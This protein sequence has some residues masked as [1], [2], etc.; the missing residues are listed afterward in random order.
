MLAIY[1]L[2]LSFLLSLSQAES[3]LGVYI[4]ARH[5]DRT[6][7]KTPPTN[8][9]GLGYQE[10]F[11]A[12]GYFRDRYVN[13]SAPAKISGLNSDIV[14]Q[15]QIVASAPVDTVLMNSAEGFL[16]ALYPPAAQSNPKLAT[17]TLRNGTIVTIP[18]NNF[19]LIPLQ[20]VGAGAGAED[21][22]WLQS[23]SG[24][25]NSIISSNNYF[26]SPQYKTILNSTADFYKSLTPLINDT[27]VDADISF[28]NA[29]SSSSPFHPPDWDSLLMYLV[30]DLINVASIHNASFDPGKTL[31]DEKFFQLRQLAD[32]HEWNLAYNSSDTI[33][34]VVGSTLASQIVTA[35]NQT[36]TSQGKTKLNIQFGPYATFQSFFG[37]AQLPAA[38][39]DFY[40]IPDYMSSMSFELFTDGDATP[41]PAATDI[42]VR[43]FSHN[44]TASD[45]S[46][47]TPFP[48]F[49]Q[50]QMALP[51]QT[52]V[53]GMNKF[54]INDEV[55]WCKACGNTTGVCASA[56][57][58]A[59]TATQSTSSGSGG[60]SKAVA[61][62]IG[63]IVT[64][65]VVLGLV[66]LAMLVGGLRLVSKKR[67]GAGSSN[68]S[69]SPTPMA[70][71]HV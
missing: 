39:A 54:A 43:F 53:D 8:L 32:L 21:T 50:K 35:L 66:V 16:Q 29:Y 13:A 70:K 37:L 27:F 3:I 41:F 20:V 65:A 5:G 1:A 24:C 38:S 45:S 60:V 63:A 64:L 25:A 44:G 56:A 49:G 15:S 42:K 67:I 69:G 33:R 17:E 22:P 6:A 51:W 61:G 57:P 11:T 71:S 48:L 12:G 55:T 46:E 28:K 9:T 36:I 14:K 40:G 4:F 59:A 52:F 7:K 34:A 31:T 18:M 2:V 19:Q 47:P 10:V 58:P 26:T 23:G 68:S 62:V 30:F